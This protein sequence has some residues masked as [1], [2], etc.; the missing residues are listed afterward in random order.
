MEVKA[1]QLTKQLSKQLHPVYLV[2]GDETLIVEEALD[3]IRSAARQAGH[4]ERMVFDV[5]SGFSWSD[6]AAE[7]Q[8]LSLFSDKKLIELRLPNARISDKGKSICEF[9]ETADGETIVIIRAPRLDKNTQKQAW[10]KAVEKVGVTTTV[11]PLKPREVE[12]WAATH[13]R[14]QGKSMDYE[15]LQLLLVKTEGNLLATKQEIDKLC[16]AI[17]TPQITL[18]ALVNS[19]ADSARYT[20][21]DLSD[22][23]LKG[24]VATTSSVFNHLKAEGAELLSLS[25]MITKEIRTLNILW[26]YSQSGSME[27]AFQKAKVWKNKQGLYRSALQRLTKTKLENLLKAAHTLDLSVKGMSDENSWHLFY[28]ICLALAGNHQFTMRKTG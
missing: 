15:A 17:D 20:I 28:E 22:N 23:C 11:W 18:E 25:G 8:A 7:A 10:Y 19:I 14:K 1:P 4:S 13:C 12:E 16:L 21:F 9:C 27:L 24:D 2:H 26:N 3:H 5:E 6:F